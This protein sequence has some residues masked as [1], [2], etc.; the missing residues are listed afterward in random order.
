[1]TKWNTSETCVKCNK[2]YYK[3][4]GESMPQRVVTSAQH[5]KYILLRHCAKRPIRKTSAT[6]QVSSVDCALETIPISGGLS[7][8]CDP[9]NAED[10]KRADS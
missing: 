1:M 6:S 5:L 8:K 10:Q 7:T 4:L 3:S 9:S 2:T